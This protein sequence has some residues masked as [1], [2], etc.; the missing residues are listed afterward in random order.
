MLDEIASKVL[1]TYWSIASFQSLYAR[2]NDWAP[3]AAAPVPTEPTLLDRW[4]LSRAPTWPP[5]STRRWRASTRPRAGKR[6][7]DLIDD[8][9]NWYVR[10]SRRRFWDG[11]PA[12]LATLHECLELLTRLL[13]PFVPFITEQV[14]QA[15]FAGPDGSIRC[16]WP[17]GRWPTRT[18]VDRRP[19]A[20]RSRSCA[21]WSSW[22]RSARAEVEGQD[23]AAAGAGPG[24]GT[25]LGRACRRAA[26]TRSRDELNVGELARLAEADELVELSVK[27]NFRE[28]GRRFGKRTQDG[29]RGDRRPRTRPRSSPP[30]ARGVASVDWSTASTVS[31]RRRRRHH[32]DAALGLGRRQRGAETVALDLELT[33]ELRLLGLLRDI[34]RMVQDARKNAGPGRHRPD[35]AVLAGRWLTGPGRGDP[36]ARRRSWPPRCWRRTSHEGAAG[37]EPTD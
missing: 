37:A 25:G 11:D 19:G 14:W 2:A 29:R 6:L 26:A 31:R 13:A 23:P 18:C 5:R 4:A 30:T 27:P 17:A 16:T 15:L 35:R 28:L 12:A 32:R 34:V 22:A 7:A 3:D 8:L 10:R 9:S 36:R 21:A 1:R 24:V 33:H 20:T